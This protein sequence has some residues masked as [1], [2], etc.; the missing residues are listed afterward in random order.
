MQ[1]E[2]LRMLDIICVN[3]RCLW[4]CDHISCVVLGVMQGMWLEMVSVSIL[5]VFLIPISADCPCITS[6]LSVKYLKTNKTLSQTEYSASLYVLAMSIEYDPVLSSTMVLPGLVVRS[7]SPLL[8][9]QRKE[10]NYVC[11]VV[12]GMSGNMQTMQTIGACVSQDQ[13][14]GQSRSDRPRKNQHNFYFYAFDIVNWII[15]SLIKWSGKDAEKINTKNFHTNSSFEF[16]DMHET[17]K[18]V[19]KIVLHLKYYY[20]WRNISC[21]VR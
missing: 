9:S 13:T 5:Q 2:S 16:L 6:I 20:L 10:A 14:P 17:F 3:T 19:L 18:N 7:L 21:V 4:V 1:P 15:W 12:R 8:F 11:L